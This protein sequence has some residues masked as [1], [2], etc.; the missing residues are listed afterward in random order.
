MTSQDLPPRMLFIKGALI[1][2]DFYCN[3]KGVGSKEGNFASLCYLNSPVTVS[4]ILHRP[5][6]W[7]SGTQN[8][9]S[10][11]ILLIFFSRS[12]FRSRKRYPETHWAGRCNSITQHWKY[13]RNFASSKYTALGTKDKKNGVRL[14]ERHYIKPEQLFC[15]ALELV[16]SLV[17]ASQKLSVST[18]PLPLHPL[19]K[20]AK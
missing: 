7:V 9:P 5:A 20:R 17:W 16:K 11:K 15:F 6:Q 14:G 1:F 4:A 10:V 18:K 8:F 19:F 12:S 13:Y 2:V 3:I